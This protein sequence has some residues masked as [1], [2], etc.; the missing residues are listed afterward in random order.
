MP[1]AASACIKLELLKGIVK[2]IGCCKIDDK[3]VLYDCYKIYDEKIYLFPYK[4]E[5]ICIIDMKTDE[6]MWLST[7]FYGEIKNMGEK[8]DI[9]KYIYDQ[10]KCSLEEYIE[11]VVRGETL[12]KKR[13]KIVFVRE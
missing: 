6:V 13:E 1:S 5:N 4:G 12:L 11:L 8:D 9:R 3:D 7:R 2:E 10:R